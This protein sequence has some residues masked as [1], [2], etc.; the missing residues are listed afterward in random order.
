MVKHVILWQLKDGADKAKIK[1]G[2]EGLDGKIPGMTYIHV[3]IDPLESS[4]CDA[5]LECEFVGFDSLKG[6]AVHPLHVE[7]AET[8][9]R[10]F[11]DTRL[12]YDF[13]K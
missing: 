9:I 6:Y 13:E 2:L 11:I 8:F 5:M 1:E 12:A 10:P 4:N 7:V 3:E